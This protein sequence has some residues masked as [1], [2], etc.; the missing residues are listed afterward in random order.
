MDK[1]YA[2]V[3]K[4][5]DAEIKA[6]ENLPKETISKVLPI[7]EI[8]RGR[9]IQERSEEEKKSNRISGVELYPLVKRLDKIKTIFRGQTVC[10]DLTTELSLSNKTIDNLYKHNNGYKNWIDFLINLKQESNFKEIIPCIVMDVEDPDFDTNIKIQVRELSKH[11]KN[12]IYRNFLS[13]DN[14]YDDI[15]VIKTEVNQNTNLLFMIDSGYIVPASHKIF[16]DKIIYRVNKVST[17]LPPNTKYIICGTS[18]PKQVSDIG[19]DFSDT[20]KLVE[21]QIF[22]NLKDS[23][24]VDLVYADY[25][26]I[27]PIRNDDIIMARGWIPRID[28]PTKSDV[29]YYRVRRPKGTSQ[30]KDTYVEVAKLVRNDDRFPS[31]IK[32][33]WGISEI[34]R[35]ADGKPSSSSPSF[36]IAVRMNIHIQ[37]QVNLL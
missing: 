12:I 34:N 9:K 18:F 30:Y 25:G 1:L 14:C 26:T 4:T 16:L 37:Q 19:N 33:N 32:S 15:E 10:F 35:C 3:I 2:V 7:I 27:N 5:G 23:C 17:I 11:F 8:T 20:F 21:K 6:I 31:S 22:N 29:Y 36:W 24:G 28:V 13:D